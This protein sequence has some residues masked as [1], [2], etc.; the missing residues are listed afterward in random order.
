M[1]HDHDDHTVLS[2]LH[3]VSLLVHPDKRLL[4][5]LLVLNRL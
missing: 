4:N 5:I 2:S 3:A 1:T